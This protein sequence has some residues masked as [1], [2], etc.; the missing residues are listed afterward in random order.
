LTFDFWSPKKDFE[1]FLKISKP[2]A[3]QSKHK[4]QNRVCGQHVLEAN[5]F[6]VSMAGRLV[7]EAI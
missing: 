5:H 7:T 1:E 4:E 2:H 3:E 6:S